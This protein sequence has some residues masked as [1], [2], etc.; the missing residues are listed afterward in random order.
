MKLIS[1]GKRHNDVG[2]T[3]IINTTSE[4]VFEALIVIEDWRRYEKAGNQNTGLPTGNES[5]H[6]GESLI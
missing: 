5:L 1:S 2:K 6:T 4:H 3:L